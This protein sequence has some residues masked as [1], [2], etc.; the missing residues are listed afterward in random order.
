MKVLIILDHY[1]PG[2]KAGGPIR[3]IA[4]LIGILGEDYE[5]SILTRDRDIDDKSPFAEAKYRRWRHSGNTRIR[6]MSPIECSLIGLG[7]ILYH[8]KYDLIYLNSFFS[9]LTIRIMIMRKIGLI[10]KGPLVLAPRGEF[11]PGAIAIKAL[12]KRPYIWFCRLIGLYRGIIWHASTKSEADDIIRQIATSEEVVRI[13][14]VPIRIA[15]DP[16]SYS[17]HHFHR[18]VESS[19]LKK[20]GEARIVFLSR[21]SRKKNLEYALKLLSR[22]SGEIQLDIY[23]PIEDVSYWRRCQNIIGSLPSSVRV[24]YAGQVPANEVQKVFGK[25]HL[26][27]FPTLGENFGHVIPEALSAGCLVLLSD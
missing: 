3:S 6:Y 25:Y 13:G 22:L 10:R 18:T 24:V 4:N 7:N 20:P 26:F 21:I 8:I 19:R 23:G 27:L 15:S 11:S 14:A 5:F 1:L 2:F 17:G 16:L 12:K 9:R